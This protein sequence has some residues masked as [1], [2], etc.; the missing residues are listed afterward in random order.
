M[1]TGSAGSQS[2]EVVPRIGKW[3]ATPNANPSLSLLL[4]DCP[5]WCGSSTLHPR[6]YDCGGDGTGGTAAR[7]EHPGGVNVVLGDASVRFV[8]DT[9]EKLTWF[10]AMSIMDGNAIGEW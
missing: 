8:S 7:S 2:S 4:C 1:S 5:P 9:I 10:Y 3:I 6:C